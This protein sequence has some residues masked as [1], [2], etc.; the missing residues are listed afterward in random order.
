MTSSE[1][2]KDKPEDGAPIKHKVGYAMITEEGIVP[3]DNPEPGMSGLAPED[4][5]LPLTARPPWFASLLRVI[6]EQW[7]EILGEMR[8]RWKKAKSKYHDIVEFQVGDK[9][10]SH[11][12]LLADLV[13]GPD[14]INDLGMMIIS[15]MKKAMEGKD[16]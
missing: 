2:D 7:P 15:D 12:I 14:I 3:I 1:H 8:W 10:Q 4:T 6:R 9:I 16:D 5:W 13:S 11:K